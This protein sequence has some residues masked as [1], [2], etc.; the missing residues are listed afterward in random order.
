MKTEITY[1][2]IDE[3]GISGIWCGKKPSKV[4]ILEERKVL[5]AEEGMLLKEKETEQ[6][7]DK[8]WLRDGDVK[9]N[10]IEFKKERITPNEN[11]N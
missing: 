9:D 7:F 5:I 2:G 6:I 3:N 4:K 11:I 1:I 8:V 10:Y